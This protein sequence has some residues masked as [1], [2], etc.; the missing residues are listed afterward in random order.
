M[1]RKAKIE[2]AVDIAAIHVDAWRVAYKG[3]IPDSWLVKLSKKKR[4]DQW[5]KTLSD[6]ASRTLVK[7][8]NS[9]QIIGWVSFGDSRND[10]KAESGEIY[11][12]Y[13]LPEFWGKGYGKQLL[14]VAENDLEKNGFTEIMIWV[15][16]LNTQTRRFYENAGYATDGG[17][18]VVS[19][20]NKELIKL[21]Y[22]KS[23]G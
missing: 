15:L 16:E 20:E 10:I 13:F 23:V 22:R 7:V 19:F 8:H 9:S 5:N 21:R 18:Q 12:I 3:I 2:D 6:T 1:I 11:A 17:K 14:K 4:L